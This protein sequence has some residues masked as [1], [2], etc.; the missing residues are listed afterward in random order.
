MPRRLSTRLP[1][2]FSFLFL[3]LLVNTGFILFQLN[4]QLRVHYS[5]DVTAFPF[6]IY[7]TLFLIL[8]WLLNSRILP[9]AAFLPVL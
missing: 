7:A 8:A 1:L 9:R 2:P 3:F 5:N 6:A 4:V